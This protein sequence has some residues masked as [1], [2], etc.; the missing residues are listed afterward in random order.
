[1]AQEKAHTHTKQIRMQRP[2]PAHSHNQECHKIQTGSH[3]IYTENKTSA[4]S[5]AEFPET[6]V[7]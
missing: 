5:S 6:S 3:S 2:T 4:F 1:M 7:K